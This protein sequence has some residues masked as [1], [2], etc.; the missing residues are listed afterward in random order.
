MQNPWKAVGKLDSTASTMYFCLLDK[1]VILG[2]FSVL[3]SRRLRSS[4]RNHIQFSSLSSST[5]PN[6][7]GK[8]IPSPSKPVAKSIVPRYLFFK[9]VLSSPIRGRHALTNPYIDAW[10]EIKRRKKL[11]STGLVQIEVILPGFVSLIL[12]QYCGNMR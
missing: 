2:M 3:V 8:S 1:I 6:A 7:K 11:L 10:Y 9:T 5:T 12:L 4:E